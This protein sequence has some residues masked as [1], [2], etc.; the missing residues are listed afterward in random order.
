MFTV[1]LPDVGKIK[2]DIMVFS[3][4]S[5]NI[6]NFPLILQA[7]SKKIADMASENRKSFGAKIIGTV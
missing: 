5:T 3:R 1:D 4:L 2:V 7:H 6:P